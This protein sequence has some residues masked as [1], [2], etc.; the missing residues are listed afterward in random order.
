MN[1]ILDEKFKE[2]YPEF[3][4]LIKNASFIAIDTELTGISTDNDVKYRLVSFKISI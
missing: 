3:E 4:K 1:E 2:F